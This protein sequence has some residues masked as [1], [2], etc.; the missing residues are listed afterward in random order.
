VAPVHEQPL[1]PDLHPS[2]VPGG[3]A[4]IAGLSCGNTSPRR[5]RLPPL[6]P[7]DR[8]PPTAPPRPERVHLGRAVLLLIDPPHP[9]LD[10]AGPDAVTA[11]RPGP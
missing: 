1:I 4:Q 10:Q 5:T 3:V 11:H 8:G 7:G 9:A 6:T 2:G